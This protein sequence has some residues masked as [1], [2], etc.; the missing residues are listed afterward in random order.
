MLLESRYE[1]EAKCKLFMTIRFVVLFADERK[2][3]FRIKAKHET[4]LS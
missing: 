3:T 4:T 2:L 1:S